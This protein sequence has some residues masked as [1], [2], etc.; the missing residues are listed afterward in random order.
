MVDQRHLLLAAWAATVGLAGAGW[1]GFRRM[2]SMDSY[3]ADIAP[4]RAALPADPDPRD[5]IRYAR[6][7]ANSH[8]TQAWQ[9]RAGNSRIDIMPDLARRTPAVDPD[10]HH[11]FA[12]HGC[13]AENLSIAAAA[14]GLP[15]EVAFDAGDG[16]KVRFDYIATTS[17][18]A[19]L[20][21]AISRRQSTRTADRTRYMG[22]CDITTVFFKPGS[23]IT[24]GNIR[25]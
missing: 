2:G 3:A 6:L 8:N 22:D 20:C 15:G 7:A 13:A 16:E 14:R 1:S 10:D 12:S 25:Q 23:H 11:L 5:L 9:F 4:V 19:A 18:D 17:R 21:D 24:Q